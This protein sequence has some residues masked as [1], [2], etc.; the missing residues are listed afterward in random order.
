M[1]VTKKL[2]K[3]ANKIITTLTI[4]IEYYSVWNLKKSSIL[5]ISKNKLIN[6]VGKTLPGNVPAVK[7]AMIMMLMMAILVACLVIGLL[8]STISLISLIIIIDSRNS[9][10]ILLIL[11]NIGRIVILVI[12]LGITT[13]KRLLIKVFLIPLILSNV[14]FL[15]NLLIII[16][17]YSLVRIYYSCLFRSIVKVI[18]VSPILFDY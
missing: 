1:K 12:T 3:F 17:L 13:K 2:L 7:L 9:S 5:L 14:W 6:Q 16:R 18:L 11:I 8:T 15:I 10:I 4:I